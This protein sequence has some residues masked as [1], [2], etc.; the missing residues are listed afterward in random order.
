MMHMTLYWSRYVT[1]LFD[2]WRTD[3]W[4]SYFVSLAA[5]F[6]VFAFYQSLASSSAAAVSPLLLK[7]GASRL[8]RSARLG[9]ALL[10]GL[11]SAIG[12]L[13][14]LAIMSFNKGVFLAIIS[15]LTVGYY[16]FR[17]EDE[18]VAVVVLDNPCACA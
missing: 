1:L 16:V 3:S 18:G 8:A 12:Y 13:L 17:F 9:V 4:P 15:G 6:L 2:S 5:C 10:F 14:M 7:A 11:N